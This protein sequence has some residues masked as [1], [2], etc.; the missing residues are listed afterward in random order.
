MTGSTSKADRAGLGRRRLLQAGA[1][2]TAAAALPARVF[3][4]TPRT[5][6][7]TLP[8]LAQ[9]ATAYSYIAQDQG[10]FKKR[11]LNVE[12]SRGYGSLAAAQ[13]IGGGQFEFG[14][15]S[16]GAT[17][18]GAAN[19]LPLVALGTTNYDAYMG[20]LVRPESPIR[21][22]KDL[23]GRK[24]GGVLTSVETPFWPA[25]AKLAGID[26]AKV[27]YIQA[28]SRVLERM[29]V[30]KQVEAAICVTSTSYALAKAIGVEPRAML[31]SDFGLNFYSNN[32]VTRPD[33]LQKDA[34]LCQGMT[35][36]LLEGLAFSLQDPDAALDIF[37][38]KVPELALTQGGREFARLGQGFMLASVVRPEAQDNSLGYTDMAKIKGMVD[39]VMDYAV[40]KGKA[41]R[42]DEQ[43]LFTNKFVGAIRLSPAQWETVKRKTSE[44]PKLLS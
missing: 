7:F 5:V 26:L 22:P 12:I 10:Y 18:V 39:L 23:E 4:Q 29:L 2:V 27:N 37:M 28:D 36:A 30:E 14:L 41:K 21:K 9:G 19:G 31:W 3:A 25:F 17:I 16:T 13:S 6:K 43:A 35:E 44:F 24:V 20:I 8:W 15:V 11:G 40:D 38:R 32:I 33:V 42:P 34:A 1:G